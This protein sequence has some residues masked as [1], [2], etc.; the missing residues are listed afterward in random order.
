MT[1]AFFCISFSGSLWL[2]AC[3]DSVYDRLTWDF[4]QQSCKKNITG[5]W[6]ISA[7][8]AFPFLE[9]NVAAGLF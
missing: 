2:L 4:L 6:M 1:T 3:S 9:A 8:F 5:W 7:F